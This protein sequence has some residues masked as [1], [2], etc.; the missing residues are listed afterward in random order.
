LVVR[1]GS[2]GDSNSGFQLDATPNSSS[3]DDWA[4]SAIPFGQSFVDAAS[5]VMMV[6]ISGD[7]KSAQVDVTVGAGTPPAPSCVRSAPALTV[8]GDGLSISPGSS[9]T[10]TLT[11]LNKDSAGCGSSSFGFQAGAPAGWAAA[12]PA[13]SIVAPGASVALTSAV[14][15]SSSSPAGS[16]TIA[17]TATNAASSQYAASANA[18]ALISTSTTTA[19][20]GGKR[21]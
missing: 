10:Y 6:A 5:G 4:D 1:I 19:K 12:S 17:Y 16:Y 14:T 20:R 21:K 3:Y 2:D 15:S 11:L 13:S 9:T 18:S 7:G 8:A